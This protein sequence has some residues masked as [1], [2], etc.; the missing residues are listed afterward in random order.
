ME[1]GDTLSIRFLTA[2]DQVVDEHLLPLG[3][4]TSPSLPSLTGTAPKIEAGAAQ[5]RRQYG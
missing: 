5:S 2:D 4:P 1:T 3:A